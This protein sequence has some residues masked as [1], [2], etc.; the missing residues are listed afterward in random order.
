MRARE[1]LARAHED[2]QATAARLDEASRQSFL[3]NVAAN[4]E[5]VALWQAA[6][7]QAQAGG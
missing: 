1:V 2:L 4:R 6:T 7:G 3:H 5:V